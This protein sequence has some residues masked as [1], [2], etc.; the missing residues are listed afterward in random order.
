MADTAATR[1]VATAGLSHEI[2]EYGKVNSV[3]EAAAAR[4]VALDRVIKT[5]VVRRAESD[6][7]MILVP[8]DRVI[9]W[10]KLRRVCGVSRMA[11]ASAEEALE[12]TGYAPGTITPFGSRTPL[13]VIADAAMGGLASIG[14]GAHGV[15]INLDAGELIAY[16]EA[17]VADVTRVT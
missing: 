4:G 13:P 15:A 9:D 2:V 6:L 10:A 11:L 5:I 16:L 8:G 7:L 3:E 12:A 14:G 1:A 17:E